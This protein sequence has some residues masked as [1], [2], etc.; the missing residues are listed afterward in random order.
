MLASW[1]SGRC[2][3]MGTPPH[4]CSVSDD[5]VV[6]HEFVGITKCLHI[7]PRTLNRYRMC[8]S[9]HIKKP[10]IR[11]VVWCVQQWV[12]RCWY[13]DKLLVT[14]VPGAIQTR[15]TAIK[16]WAV[17]SRTGRINVYPDLR[18]TPPNTQCPFTAWL[19]LYSR[20]PNL[21]SSISTSSLG[22]LAFW[23]QPST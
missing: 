7:P 10:I 11:L 13:T 20:R 14:A 15:R 9:T 17:L 2:C 1:G 4:T 19:L 22:P 8:P 16:V 18:C 21:L 6:D 12:Y 3:G 5:D 23:E